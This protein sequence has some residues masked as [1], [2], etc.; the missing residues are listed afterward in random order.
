MLGGLGQQ[1]LDSGRHGNAGS[2]NGL[3]RVSLQLTAKQEAVAAENRPDFLQSAPPLSLRTS[4]TR[5]WAPQ[6]QSRFYE[7]ICQHI[8]NSKKLTPR[9]RWAFSALLGE[10]VK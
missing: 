7:R 4:M 5:A 9:N 3:M 10:I 6:E 8:S 1:F 2:P